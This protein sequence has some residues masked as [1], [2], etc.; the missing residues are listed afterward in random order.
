MR[1]LIDTN[2]LIHLEDDKV[3]DS[4]FSKFYQ[5]TISNKCDLFYHPDCL[6][7][8]AN[9]KDEKRKKIILSKLEKYSSFPKPSKP[10]AEFLKLVTEKKSNDRID[11]T[12]LY[13]IYKGYVD[14]F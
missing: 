14:L 4:T 8:L 13:Q 1:I 7:D 5:L 10:D 3:I 12:Q 11:N 6:K 9:D 2:I